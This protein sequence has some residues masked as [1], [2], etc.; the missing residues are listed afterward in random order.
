M[1]RLHD[2][3]GEV[4]KEEPDALRKSWSEASTFNTSS[5]NCAFQPPP[6]GEKG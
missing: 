6:L 2:A 1:P 5:R 4:G 3:A